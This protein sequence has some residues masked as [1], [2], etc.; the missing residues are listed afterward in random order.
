MSVAGGSKI[1]SIDQFVPINSRILPCAEFWKSACHERGRARHPQATR[2]VVRETFFFIP[3]GATGKMKNKKALRQGDLLKPHL[4]ARQAPSC[5][6][7]APC[8][9]PRWAPPQLWLLGPA[10]VLGVQR[11]CFS[12][13][14]MGKRRICFSPSRGMTWGKREPA[15]LA[16]RTPCLD[17]LRTDPGRSLVCVCNNPITP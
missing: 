3:D 17:V 4:P 12:W 16:C 2:T 10:A 8:E 6:P 14:G 13:L 9:V 5:H 15:P 1:G 7:L 11:C